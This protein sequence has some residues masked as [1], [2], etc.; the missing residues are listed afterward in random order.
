MLIMD[1]CT[2]KDSFPLSCID[3][4]YG[5]SYVKFMIHFDLRYAYK[6]RL[7]DSGLHD[8]SIAATSL[9]RPHTECFFCFPSMLK[10][11]EHQCSHDVGMFLGSKR[12]CVIF[13]CF[14]LPICGLN[15]LKHELMFN[16]KLDILLEMLTYTNDMLLIFGEKG[17]FF[18]RRDVV[19]PIS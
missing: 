6:L 2:V 14:Y 16:S 19:L 11:K 3:M 10:L 13:P 12:N 8:E 5:L 18:L 4:I 7:S 15:F 9:P 1:E 17:E